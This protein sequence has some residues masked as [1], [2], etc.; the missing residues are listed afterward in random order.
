EEDEEEEEE[1][2]R[3]R[4]R[5]DDGEMEADG[6]EM[7]VREDEERRR[8]EEEE[9]LNEVVDGVDGEHSEEEQ[10]ERRGEGGMDSD[11]EER[12]MKDRREER[13]RAAEDREVD[14]DEGSERGN[15]EDEMAEGV[16]GGNGRGIE[17]DESGNEEEEG[18][19]E[20]MEVDESDDDEEVEKNLI[21]CH[22]CSLLFRTASGWYGHLKEIHHTTPRAKGFFLRCDCGHEGES[23]QHSQVCEIS[24]FTVLRRPKLVPR[25]TAT[26][27][28]E[29]RPA[30]ARAF[31]AHLKLA[32]KG[33]TLN[34][35][36]LEIICGCGAT[37]NSHNAHSKK[38]PQCFDKDYEVRPKKK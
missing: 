28:C 23:K 25:C 36:Q 24:N 3:G 22:I 17:R 16:Q 34:G 37:I 27:D 6:R 5:E 30:T 2:E 26:A 38:H 32:H 21:E 14:V 7:E 29:A 33:Q 9:E 11:E 12:E 19:R 20:D 4:G 31:T 10:E 35:M 1:G 13:R 8:E 18:E 15:E